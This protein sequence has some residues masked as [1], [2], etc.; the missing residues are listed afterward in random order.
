MKKILITS[1]LCLFL[2][3]VGCKKELEPTY[4]VNPITLNPSTSG[5]TKLKTNEQFVAILHA[6]LFQ[7]A[8]SANQIFEISQTIEAVGDKSLVRELVINNMLNDVSKKV[9]KPTHVEMMADVDKFVNDTYKRF[10]IRYPTE[11][12]KTYVKNYIETWGKDSGGNLDSTK[13]SPEIVYFSFVL[14]NE[15]LYY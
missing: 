1:T 15:Y 13:I 14:S 9:L 8:L 3:V 4:D 5:K 12:E 11:A 6:N 7:K 2:F 10:Y